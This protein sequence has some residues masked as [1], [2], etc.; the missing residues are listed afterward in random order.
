MRHPLNAARIGVTD[1]R[2]AHRP[3]Y[4]FREVGRYAAGQP[5]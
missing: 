5:H 1:L 3:V 2:A 4:R